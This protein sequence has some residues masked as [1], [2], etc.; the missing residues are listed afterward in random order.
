M[1]NT[2]DFTP[3]ESLHLIQTMITKTKTSVAADSF[4]LLFWGWLVFASCFI[5]YILKVI[6]KYPDHYI[7]WWLMPIGGIVSAIYGARQAK[8]QRVKTF[9]EEARQE[10]R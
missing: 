5:E 3:E 2:N 6:V 4:Y 1:E 8:K 7:I 9:V 10:R